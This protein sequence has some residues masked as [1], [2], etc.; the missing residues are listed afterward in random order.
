MKTLAKIRYAVSPIS[1]SHLIVPVKINGEGPFN[2]ILDTGASAVCLSQT[3]AKK[4]KLN[5]GSHQEAMSASGTFKIKVIT[6]RSL[7][8]GKAYR[9]K[10]EVAIMNLTNISEKLNTAIDGILGYD[11]LKKYQL[12]INYPKKELLLK[13]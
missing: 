4:L 1:E 6:I 5:G 11:Y 2:F 13:K 10:M 9:K 7:S 3:L 12:V 8:I